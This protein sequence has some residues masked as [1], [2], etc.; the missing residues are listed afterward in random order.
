M[1]PPIACQTSVF[2]SAEERA[3][4]QAL[5]VRIDAAVTS[6]VEVERGFEIQLPGDDST[7]ALVADWIVLERRCCPFFEFMVSIGCSEMS[8]RIWG[9]YR[10]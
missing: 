5:R 6:I 8:I 3:H 4:Y 2:F 1:D 10:G 9:Q 7:L